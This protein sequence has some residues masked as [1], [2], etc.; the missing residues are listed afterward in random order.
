[1]KDGLVAV[2]N[3]VKVLTPLTLSVTLNLSFEL[4]HRG[5][6]IM[7]HFQEAET[8]KPILSSRYEDLLTRDNVL[9]IW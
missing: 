7:Y 9:E 6:T 3:F 8:N 5:G 1:M 2:W 4:P